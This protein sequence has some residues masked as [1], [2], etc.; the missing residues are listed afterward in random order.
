MTLCQ[1]KRGEKKTRKLNVNQ[2]T[3]QTA[4]TLED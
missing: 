2:Q 4:A 1:T 3:A